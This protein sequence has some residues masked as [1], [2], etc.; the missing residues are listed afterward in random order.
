MAT[1]DENAATL[2]AYWAYAVSNDDV[3]TF[4]R[5]V[6]TGAN[7]DVTGGA[8]GSEP[9]SRLYYASNA[10]TELMDQCAGNPY[11]RANSFAANAIFETALLSEA[12]GVTDLLLAD[13]SDYVY[14]ALHGLKAP[15]QIMLEAIE[16]AGTGGLFSPGDPSGMT[17]W[18]KSVDVAGPAIV[19]TIKIDPSGAVTAS[20]L[21]IVRDL[22]LPAEWLSLIKQEQT[23]ETLNNRIP[24]TTWSS[25]TIADLALR[26]QLQG[27]SKAAAGRVGKDLAQLALSNGGVDL[28]KLPKWGSFATPTQAQNLT[29]AVPPKPWYKSG[30]VL[31]GGFLGLL[32][33]AGFAMHRSR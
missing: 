9:A 30:Q 24:V 29:T 23:F 7:V 10:M 31:A 3:L 6:R 12:I 33:G 20:A 22:A 21:Q 16:K 5:N 4:Y 15:R 8:I 18:V 14:G 27:L 28:T 1:P 32:G 26:T 17:S 2:L 11:A 19:S 25:N 13:T